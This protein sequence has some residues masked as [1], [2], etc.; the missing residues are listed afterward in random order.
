MCEFIR[1]HTTNLGKAKFYLRDSAYWIEIDK[2]ICLV[3]LNEV[4]KLIH[5]RK[6]NVTIE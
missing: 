3:V 2:D 5:L 1:K 4:S 6:L